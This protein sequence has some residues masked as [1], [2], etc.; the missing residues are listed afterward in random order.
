MRHQRHKRRGILRGHLGSKP[1]D[2]HAPG[3]TGKNSANTR[4]AVLPSRPAKV[5]RLA[6]VG[7]PSPS[8]L[9]EA[10]M[11]SGP[12]TGGLTAGPCQEPAKF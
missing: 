11:G 9:A 6:Q 10:L 8:A 5:T 1:A 12:V 2:L 3:A 4:Q 7:R